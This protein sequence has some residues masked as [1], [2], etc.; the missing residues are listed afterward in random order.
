MDIR[1]LKKDVKLKFYLNVVFNIL[2]RL[3]LTQIQHA[4]DH[5]ADSQSQHKIAESSK[6]LTETGKKQITG[7]CDKKYKKMLKPAASFSLQ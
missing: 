6:K 5:I 4:N 2:V 3:K 7:K 1:C